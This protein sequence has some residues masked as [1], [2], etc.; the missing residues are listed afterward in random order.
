MAGC[1]VLLTGIAADQEQQVVE[2]AQRLGARIAPHFCAGITHVVADLDENLLLVSHTLKVMMGIAS[3]KVRPKQ[4][5]ARARVCVCVCMCG[6][7]LAADIFN[8]LLLCCSVLSHTRS[9]L[10][11]RPS[12]SV[13][14]RAPVCAY[15][16]STFD[17]SIAMAVDRVSC[18]ASSM[19]HSQ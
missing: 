11:H 7:V 14:T 4:A 2:T 9:L 10:P 8:V 6:W 16:L 13:H 18:L 1:M 5:R 19:Q 15:L 17:L 3:G 12:N